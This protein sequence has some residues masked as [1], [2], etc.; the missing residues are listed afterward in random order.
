M[1]GWITGRN[2]QRNGGRRLSLLAEGVHKRENETEF[3]RK[4]RNRGKEKKKMEWKERYR[5]LFIISMCGLNVFKDKIS[6]PLIGPRDL[7][8]FFSSYKYIDI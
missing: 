3:G 5:F 2:C 7:V 1:G 8:F 4:K 6:W